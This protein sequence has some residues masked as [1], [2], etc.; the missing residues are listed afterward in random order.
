MWE[1]HPRLPNNGLDQCGSYPILGSSQI[2]Y[3]NLFMQRIFSNLPSHTGVR[4]FFHFYQ[5]DDIAPGSVRFILNG[6]EIPYT[7]ILQRRQ[8][9]GNNTPDGISSIY[10]EDLT[11]EEGTVNLTI[12]AEHFSKIGVNDLLLFLLN[13]PSCQA[14]GYN[15]DVLPMYSAD[16][17]PEKGYL[18]RMQFDPPLRNQTPISQALNFNI[19]PE[20]RRLLQ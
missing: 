19:V 10:L 18:I 11:H 12:T 2:R 1:L 3:K 13:C 14:I 7:P 4:V 15:V 16:F 17:D 8:I 5:I 9:C 20:A 6:N